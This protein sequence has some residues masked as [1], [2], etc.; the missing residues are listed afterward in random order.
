LASI[1]LIVALA[2]DRVIGKD[3]GL[4]WRIPADLK[5]FRSV[6][7]GK[8]VLMGRKTFAS[9]G[10]PLPGRRNI[11]LTRDP[12]FRPA[13]V[14]VVTD[15]DAALAEATSAA[16]DGEVMVIGGAQVY[17]AALPSARRL[18]LTEVHASVAGD[19]YF[20]VLDPS[21]WAERSRERHRQEQPLPLD[22]SFVVLERLS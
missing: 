17:A 16:G 12:G 22:F 10:R 21:R 3:G 13:G 7:M 18:Y 14:T 4:P 19:T 11:V 15:I 1:A 6:T 2:E 20:P 5:F 8:P 9:I